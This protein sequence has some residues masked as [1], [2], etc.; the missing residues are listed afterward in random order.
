MSID[1]PAPAGAGPGETSGDVRHE[2]AADG[3][4]YLTA[5]NNAAPAE[6]RDAVASGILLWSVPWRG[7]GEPYFE[8]FDTAAGPVLKTDV[9]IGHAYSWGWPDAAAA[10]RHVRRHTAEADLA[11]D[12]LRHRGV[13]LLDG[14]W[15]AVAEQHGAARAILHTEHGPETR[16][17]P[18]RQQALDAAA[19]HARDACAW[20]GRLR[21]TTPAARAA[22]RQEAI[23]AVAAA[24]A[25][26]L[27]QDPPRPTL[28][29]RALRA[30]AGAL[31]MRPWHGAR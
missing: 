26:L 9:F 5:F 16:W 3:T 20:A 18:G 4:P 14:P 24:I 25:G 17:Y 30:C 22:E 23:G 7:F 13:I 1:T 12:Y 10:V 19:A 2:T 8:L 21:G 27:P 15:G 28:A 6:V 29:A 31:H 11:E